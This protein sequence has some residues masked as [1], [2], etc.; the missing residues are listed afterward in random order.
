MANLNV[1][2]PHQLPQDEALSRVQNA[3]AQAK[4]QHAG[5]VSIL[6]ENWTGYV[7]AFSVSVMG[8]TVSGSLTVNPSDV[9]LESSLPGPAVF[10]KGQIES[11][12]R[13][14]V[15]GILA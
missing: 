14:V 10:V 8:F 6:Q 9:T 15:S 12:A 5:K 7:G 11:T 13:E 4:V 2:V 3:I 1:T